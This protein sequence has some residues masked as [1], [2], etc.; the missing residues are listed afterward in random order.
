MPTIA[1]FVEHLPSAYVFPGNTGN[2]VNT[3]DI[4]RYL[5]PLA[6]VVADNPQ[7]GVGW[8]NKM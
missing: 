3:E 2:T 6:T 7:V 4:R 8:A 1:L 5:S